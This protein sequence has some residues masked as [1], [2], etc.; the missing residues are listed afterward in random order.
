M[1]AKHETPTTIAIDHL[2][3]AQ[4]LLPAPAPN[5]SGFLL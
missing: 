1:K 5:G 4:N 3:A 2:M